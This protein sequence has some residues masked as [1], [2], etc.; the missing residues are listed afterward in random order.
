MGILMI[1]FALW[2][3]LFGLIVGIFK[4]IRDGVVWAVTTTLEA[5]GKAREEK[6][7]RE[8]SQAK[9][10]EHY[11]TGAIFLRLMVNCRSEHNEAMIARSKSDGP[12][13][14]AARVLREIANTKKTF[15]RQQIQAL[16]L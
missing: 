6:R 2:C 16:D 14:H 9:M 15:S 10:R 8:E 12:E 13:V 5:P 3:A 7:Q 4:A 11:I 1:K